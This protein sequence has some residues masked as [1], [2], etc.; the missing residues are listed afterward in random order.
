[1]A[2]GYWTDEGDK[3]DAVIALGWEKLILSHGRRGG[4]EDPWGPNF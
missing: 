3:V 1:M 2:R 4:L